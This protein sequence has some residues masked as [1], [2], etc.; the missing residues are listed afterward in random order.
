MDNLNIFVLPE[1]ENVQI[2]LL[3]R[4][5]EAAVSSYPFCF[6]NFLKVSFIYGIAIHT[7][8]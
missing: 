8:A 2:L 4:I 1:H 6:S 3:K 7:F 5:E